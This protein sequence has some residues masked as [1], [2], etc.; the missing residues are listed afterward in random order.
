MSASQGFLEEMLGG[1]IEA[2]HEVVDSLIEASLETPPPAGYDN[3]AIRVVSWFK[4]L[5]RMDEDMVRLYCAAAFE[6]VRRRIMF[7]ASNG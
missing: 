1:R 7:E 3:E 5:E 6:Q 4:V 2:A